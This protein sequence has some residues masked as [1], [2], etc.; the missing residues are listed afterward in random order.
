MRITA[1]EENET[2][3]LAKIYALE[4]HERE[5]FDENWHLDFQ[6][7]VVKVEMERR[8]SRDVESKKTVT[9]A[10]VELENAKDDFE[11]LESQTSVDWPAMRIALEGLNSM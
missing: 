8:E 5:L 11:V 10:N 9:H 4:S 3:Q 1:L 7:V 6:L 2:E